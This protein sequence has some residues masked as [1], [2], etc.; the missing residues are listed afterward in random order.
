MRSIA[1]SYCSVMTGERCPKTARATSK[2]ASRF[3][4]QRPQVPQ[5]VR[6]ALRL[7]LVRV[8]AL[9]SLGDGTAVLIRRIAVSGLPLGM[10][11]PPV[12][13]GRLHWGLAMK[14]QG[15]AALFHVPPR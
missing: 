3:S 6:D 1:T 5:L 14:S 9:D 15:E 2:P 13:L 12:L 4:S 10:F 11:L 8:V 7:R